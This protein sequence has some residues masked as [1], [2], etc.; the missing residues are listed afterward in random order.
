[1]RTNKL[2]CLCDEHTRA[3]WSHW[4]RVEQIFLFYC[5][6]CQRRGNRKATCWLRR[7]QSSM[8]LTDVVKILEVWKSWWYVISWFKALQAAAA[9]K[10]SLKRMPHDSKS[11]RADKRFCGLQLVAADIGTY[12]MILE[13]LS[14]LSILTNTAIVGFTS[15]GLFFYIPSLTQVRAIP[16]PVCQS[17]WERCVRFLF[18]YVWVYAKGVYDFSSRLWEWIGKDRAF[19]LRVFGSGLERCVRF[20][21]IFVWVYEKGEYDSSSRSWEFIRKDCAIPL[22]VCGCVLERGVRILFAFMGDY[23]KGECIGKECAFPLRVC[24]CVMKRSVRFLFLLIDLRTL[25]AF[26][27][28]RSWERCTHFIRHSLWGNWYYTPL[29]VH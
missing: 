2:S 27:A 22:R 24:G 17:L 10:C 4:H 15:H 8:C 7:H 6:I 18:R 9:R 1:M 21:F 16:F 20:L 23:L 29:R 11:N 13:I 5:R 19:P 14:T 26:S 25:R 12:Q 3:G 28:W